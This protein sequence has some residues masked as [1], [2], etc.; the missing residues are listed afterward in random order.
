MSAEQNN[1]TQPRFRTLLKIAIP[2]LAI[3]LLVG[4]GCT[5][6]TDEPEPVELSFWGVFDGRDVYQP[7]IERYQALHP[8]VKITYSKLTI[9][10]YEQ[11]VVEALA[12][13]RGPDVWLLQNAW[14]PR[15]L[16][17]LMPASPSVIDA[18]TIQQSFVDSVYED[19]VL[20]PAPSADGT[21][22]P[23][24][25]Y[26]V[27]LYVDTLAMY[28]NKDLLQSQG[29]I[30]PPDN[31]TEFAQD[32]RTLTVTD[33]FGNVERSG[34]A[35]GTADNIENSGDLLALLMLQNQTPMVDVARQRATF[36]QRVTRADGEQFLPGLDALVFYT[37][38]ANPKKSVYTWDPTKA[39]S[40]DAFVNEEAA[41][42]FHYQYVDSTIQ[43]RAPQLNYQIAPIPQ[44]AGAAKD[45]TYAN[46]WA[47]VVSKASSTAEQQEAW[48]FIS[49]LASTDNA[50]TYA[51]ASGRP[52][53]RRDVL[54]AQLTDPDVAVFAQQALTARTWFRQDSSLIEN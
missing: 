26:G 38:F 43:A 30:N 6:G 29:I 22:L 46:S 7:L 35:M 48:R 17:K 54:E 25:V 15:H 19:Y 13:G 36:D 4:A 37:D 52:S 8:N 42:L 10:R 9:D 28:Y 44:I 12:A 49:F 16:D 24:L 32:V 51:D 11:D 18:A 40:V 34:A 1:T 33:D 53:S 31:W 3:L 39:N 23:P 21:Q 47:H 27:P 50:T 41:F 2:T 45:I 20:V 5:R 14:L